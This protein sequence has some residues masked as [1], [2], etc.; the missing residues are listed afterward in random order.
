M[1]MDDY[2]QQNPNDHWHASV[3]SVTDEAGETLERSWFQREP[4]N[5][6]RAVMTLLVTYL[7]N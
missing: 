2:F 6:L 7:S 3:S 4:P 1:H 5:R